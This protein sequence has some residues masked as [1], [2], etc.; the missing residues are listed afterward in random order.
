MIDSNSCWYARPT[1]PEKSLRFG[2][3]LPQFNMWSLA[4]PGYGSIKITVFIPNWYAFF[5]QS[6]H[7]LAVVYNRPPLIDIP[8][9]FEICKKA[10]S[11]ACRALVWT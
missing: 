3:F 9:C 1:A 2:M 4:I 10:F 11:S 7:G 6:S 5:A 8:P